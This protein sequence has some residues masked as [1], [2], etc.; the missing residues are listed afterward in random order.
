MA[1]EKK[2]E[3]ENEKGDKGHAAKEKEERQ[4]DHTPGQKGGGAERGDGHRKRTGGN[5][6]GSD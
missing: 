1:D 4:A 2:D 6:E 3:P 5:P